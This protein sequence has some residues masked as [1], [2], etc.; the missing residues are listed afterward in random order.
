MSEWW[1]NAVSGKYGSEQSWGYRQFYLG[2]YA[3]CVLPIMALKFQWFI[4]LTPLPLAIL[5]I[6]LVDNVVSM[7][8]ISWRRAKPFLTQFCMATRGEGGGGGTLHTPW[9]YGNMTPKPRQ[10]LFYSMWPSR[11]SHGIFGCVRHWVIA[12]VIHVCDCLLLY[13]LLNKSNKREKKSR[14]C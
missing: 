14:K 7:N 13:Y 12:T 10:P 3:I 6:A 11:Q 5:S 2:L 8:Q 4:H 9:S 1:F